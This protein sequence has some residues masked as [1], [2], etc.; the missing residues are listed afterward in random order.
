MFRRS[1]PTRES[2]RLW[3]WSVVGGYLPPQWCLLSSRINRRL[4]RAKVSRP[5]SPATDYEISR[6]VSAAPT[7][8]TSQRPGY[9]T[10]RDQADK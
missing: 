7:C 6:C 10:D 9:A 5:H 2:L 4:G 8:D 3:L 1:N